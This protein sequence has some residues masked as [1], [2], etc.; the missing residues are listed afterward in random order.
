MV[1]YGWL[2]VGVPNKKT[3]PPTNKPF[4]HKEPP[5]ETDSTDEMNNETQPTKKSSKKMSWNRQNNP[6]E[7]NNQPRDANQN[8]DSLPDVDP[9]TDESNRT[10]FEP[11]KCHCDLQQKQ[12]NANTAKF[13]GDPKVLPRIPDKSDLLK[14]KDNQPR[15]KPEDPHSLNANNVKSDLLEK[16]YNQPRH[17]SEEVA[18]E[19]LSVET[20]PNYKLYPWSL[21]QEVSSTFESHT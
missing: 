4:N 9:A 8:I 19:Y 17:K 14:M 2:K 6:A 18:M 10:L 5:K 11:E 7:L 16:K 20:D 1:T 3:T 12:H 13:V 15:N 21:L